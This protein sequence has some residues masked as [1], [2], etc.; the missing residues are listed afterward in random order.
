MRNNITVIKYI[1]G[2]F[3]NAFGALLW[4]GFEGVF[5]NIFIENLVMPR[6]NAKEVIKTIKK[7]NIKASFCKALIPRIHFV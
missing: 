4:P 3:L 2:G 5:F 7:F 1:Y 6:D